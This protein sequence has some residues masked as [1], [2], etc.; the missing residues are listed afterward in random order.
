MHPAAEPAGPEPTGRALLPDLARGCALLGIAVVNVA[1]FAYPADTGYSAAALATPQDRAAYFLVMAL[2]ALKSYSLFAMMFGAGVG[3][4]FD[5]AQR[6]GRPAGRAYAR[7]LLGLALLGAV[8]VWALFMGDIL[9]LYAALGGLLWALCR[10]DAARLA[11]WGWACYALQL[12]LLAAVAALLLVWHS[13]AP[14]EV[15]AEVARSAALLAQA[16]AGFGADGFLE[17]AQF[18]VR[19]WAEAIGPG[20]LL[21]GPGALAF[22]LLG[23]AALRRGWLQDVAHPQWQRCRRWWLP[24]GL[25]VSAAGAGLVVKGDMFISPEAGLGIVLLTLGSPAATMGYL[26]LLAWWA[27][28]PAGAVRTALARA[29][30]ASLSAYLLQGLLLSLVFS[31]YGLGLYAQPGAAACIGIAAAAG[32]GSIILLAAWR[33]R[34][35]RGPVEALLRGFG[36][37]G[38]R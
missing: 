36:S 16:Q 27:Q 30:G 18:R 21:Q 7:R 26:G 2:F 31:G 4:Q 33:R 14:D 3:Q 28:R 11:I 13:Q 38:R 19:A 35:G 29:G 20:L 5:A 10:R 9:L 6:Q 25:V 23:L 8:N 37:P 1:M 17:V 24:L 22:M 34:F 32:L 15:A 12:L